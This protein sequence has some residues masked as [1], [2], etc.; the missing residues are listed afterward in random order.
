MLSMCIQVQI[1]LLFSQ[2]IGNSSLSW[3]LI[4]CEITKG[5]ITYRGIA[6]IFKKGKGGGG[7]GCKEPQADEAPFLFVIVFYL[8]Y[9][10]L[11]SLPQF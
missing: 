1:L 6:G 3:L 2:E 5:V 10:D 9:V 8:F 4:W 7:R 11:V